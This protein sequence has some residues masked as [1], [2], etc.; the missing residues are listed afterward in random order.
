MG[1]HLAKSMIQGTD[2]AKAIMAT[3]AKRKQAVKLQQLPLSL[4][5]AAAFDIVIVGQDQQGEEVQQPADSETIML[6]GSGY[7]N[8]FM[9]RHR[10]IIR[11]KRSVKFEAKR[12]EWC[13]YENFSEMYDHIYEA[14][15]K[16]GIASK[17]NTK[18]KLDKAGDIVDFSDEAFAVPMQYLMQRPDKLIFVDEVGSNTCTTKDGHVGGEKFLCQADAR[19]Q[20]KA[21]TKDSHFTVLG[22]TAAT[23]EPVMCAIIFSAK[24][25]CESWVLGFNALAPWVGDDN[26]V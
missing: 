21:S 24:E 3:R 7:W 2:I 14:M 26:N 6:L 18:V 25:M 16:H 10:H 22:F 12:A 23:G 17:C 20:I 19:P 4:S 13:T 8:R 5:I 1:L 9:R 15:V 11:S